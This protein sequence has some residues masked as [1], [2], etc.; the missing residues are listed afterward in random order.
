MTVLCHSAEKIPK[1]INCEASVDIELVRACHIHWEGQETI[2]QIIFRIA[3][4]FHRVNTACNI[5]SKQHKNSGENTSF[6]V[7]SLCYFSMNLNLAD[8]TCTVTFNHLVM[9]LEIYI[10]PPPP[11]S[12][13][14]PTMTRESL[15]ELCYW[16]RVI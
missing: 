14:S 11:H 3:S 12:L 4:S 9:I 6:Y 7:F 8:M 2:K 13:H 5:S 16:S 10:S 15:T 1:Q